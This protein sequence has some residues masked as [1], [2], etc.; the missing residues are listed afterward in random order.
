M[1]SSWGCL[2][3]VAMSFSVSGGHNAEALP[4]LNLVR[5]PQVAL[6]VFRTGSG[7]R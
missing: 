7:D 4:A 1:L 2:T 5:F 3:A 6:D